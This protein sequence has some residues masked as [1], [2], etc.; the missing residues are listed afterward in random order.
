MTKEHQS[1]G[2][3][4]TDLRAGDAD[5]ERIAERLRKGHAEG[6]LDLAEFQERLERCYDAKTF[7]ELRQLVRDLP[8]QNDQ[9]PRRS[10]L[11]SWPWRVMPLAPFLVA[12]VVVSA[13]TGHHIFWFWIPLAFFWWRM[14]WSRRRQWWAHSR[15]R[16]HDVI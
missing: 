12:L 2:G 13:A 8:R 10:S 16:P 6:R 7:G 15:Y 1:I 4:D 9:N 3:R 11:S 5:R 14:S